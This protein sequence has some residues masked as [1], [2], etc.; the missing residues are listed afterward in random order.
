MKR[1]FQ[2]K[3]VVLSLLLATSTIPVTSILGLRQSTAIA[4]SLSGLEMTITTGGDDLREG[5][6]AY[7]VVELRGGRREKVNL[8]GGRGWGNNSTNKVFIPLPGG[9]KLDDLISFTLEH[10]GPPRRFPDSYDNWNVDK[11]RVATAKTCSAGVR[12]ANSSGRPFVRF[13]GGKTFQ[14]ITLNSPS[15]ARNTPVSRLQVTITTGGDDL[16]GGSVAYGEIKLQNGT[17]LSKVNLNQGRG[18]GNNSTNTVSI[19]LQSGTKIGDLASL[20]IEHDGAPRDVFQGYD[21]WNVDRAIVATPEA[22]S[23]EVQLINKTGRPLVRFTG[24]DTFRKYPINQ[25]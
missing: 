8:N 12:L 7:G 14:D 1:H 17:T 16:R 9:T 2:I 3:N 21:N 4:Q 25:R 6:V 19:P 22:C 13:T 24:A 15:S 10:A 23:T 18:W 20:R 11:L 5:S